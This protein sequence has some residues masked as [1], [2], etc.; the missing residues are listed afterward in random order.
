MS[1]LQK[2]K[3]EENDRAGIRHAVS[4]AWCTVL[5]SRGTCRS[6]KPSGSS[7]KKNKN[8]RTH[9]QENKLGDPIN[10]KTCGCI[11]FEEHRLRNKLGLCEG[12]REMRRVLAWILQSSLR[13]CRTPQKS[14][15]AAR[16][17][18]QKRGNRARERE[19]WWGW[20]RAREQERV[21]PKARARV[22]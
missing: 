15:R 21:G 13:T 8:R 12:G 18:E 17:K 19:P 14:G 5:S 1:V 11:W 3:V 7:S 4:A 9:E 10:K 2:A 6:D 16:E 20:V 22:I